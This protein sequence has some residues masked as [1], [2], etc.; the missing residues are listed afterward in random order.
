MQ[1]VL[2][3]ELNTLDRVSVAVC[4]LLVIDD[5]LTVDDAI[6][7]IRELRGPG[8]IQSVKV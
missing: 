8:A 1:I 6:D 2:E 7:K 5:S 4:T 3:K